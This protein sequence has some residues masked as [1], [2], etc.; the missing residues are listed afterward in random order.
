MGPS[1]QLGRIFGIPVEVNISWIL[2]FLLLTY[3]LAGEFEDARLRWPMAQRWSVAMITVVLFF[4]SVLLHELSHSVMALSKGIPVRGITLFIFGGVSRLDKEPERPLIEFMVAAV[5]PLMSIALA[6]VLGGI[7]FLMGRGDSPVEVVLVLLMWTNLS[8][9]VFNL[10][11]G[12]PLDGGRLLRAGIWGLTGNHRKATRISSGMGLLVGGGM[13]L[14]G[15]SLA[16]FLEP[17]DGVWL[18]IV[19][20]FLFSMA[21][22]SFPK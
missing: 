21:K 1:L 3:L 18:A 2:V 5:G 13:L 9:G 10:V 6:A 16:V 20:A 7:W 22:S 11:P 15:I 19:G 14:G 8:L 17:V 12:Y 4:L